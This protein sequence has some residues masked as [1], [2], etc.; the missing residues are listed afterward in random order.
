MTTRKTFLRNIGIGIAGLCVA[1][2]GFSKLKSEPAP[3]S[4]ETR[5]CLSSIEKDLK[6]GCEWFMFEPNHIVTR[7][8]IVIVLSSLLE[9]YKTKRLIN[10]YEVICDETNNPESV[11]DCINIRVVVQPSRTALHVVYDMSLTATI[12]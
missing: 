9:T 10:E 11:E 6:K 4:M 12:L 5:R 7:T 2:L 3:K 8:R 1:P